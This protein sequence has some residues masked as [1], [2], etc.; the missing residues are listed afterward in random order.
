MIVKY[1]CDVIRKNPDVLSNV[2][3]LK[4]FLADMPLSEDVQPVHRNAIVYALQEGVVRKLQS[5]GTGSIE[6]IVIRNQATELET[7]TGIRADLAEWAVRCW[8]AVLQQGSAPLSVPSSTPNPASVSATSMGS[9]NSQV[10]P[11]D[12]PA[13]SVEST[14]EKR[15]EKFFQETVA[16][17]V[18]GTGMNEFRV[19]KLR[20]LASRLEITPQRA[21][22]LFDSVDATSPSTKKHYTVCPYGSGDFLSINAALAAV[23]PHSIVWVRPGIYR[24]SVNLTKPV[25]LVAEGI[26]GGV[27]L[28]QEN[29][30]CI[31]VS[32]HSHNI[33][34]LK[35][36]NEGRRCNAI[37]VIKGKLNVSDCII[38]SCSSGCS[39]HGEQA[40]VE[41]HFSNISNCQESGLHATEG[42]RAILKDGIL[43]YNKLCAI[44]AQ[45]RAAVDIYDSSILCHQAVSSNSLSVVKLFNCNLNGGIIS[46]GNRGAIFIDGVLNMH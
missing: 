6:E 7:N 9:S 23:D 33:N 44:I 28:F 41:I 20:D 15:K 22:Q 29:E 46:S 25:D 42:S 4:A 35:V 26:Q 45:E 34:G 37:K 31:V 17:C 10:N 36:F 40:T 43:N 1:L 27:V 19:E 5:R 3:T 2:T 11:F 30:R 18:S 13:E 21:K 32:S 39:V 8:V 38:N 24:E 12:D 16:L 14:P